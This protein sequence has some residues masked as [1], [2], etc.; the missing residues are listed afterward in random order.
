MLLGKV[1][2]ALKLANEQ[3]DIAG[4]H[5]LDDEPASEDAILP[6]EEQ[7]VE[8][9]TYEQ[10][11]AEAVERAARNM[12]GSGG[13]TQVDADIWKV[14]VCSKA[15]GNATLALRE[16]ITLL[17]RR[18]C[19]EEIPYENIALL[20]SNRLV[21]LRKRDD[22]VRPV[23][24]GETLRRI[25]GKTVAKAFKEDIQNSCGPL[26]TCTGIQSGIEAAIHAVKNI[27]LQDDCEAVLLVDADNAFNR[28][29]REV[30]LKNVG[31]ICPVI[32]QYIHNSYK[33]PAKLYLPDGSHILSK[34][35]TTQGD[36]I[37][38]GMYAIGTKPLIDK[39]H[40]ETAREQVMQV[41]F[42]DDSTAGGKIQGI[43]TWWNS[44]KENGPKYGYFPKPEKTYLIVKDPRK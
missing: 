37:A 41:W 40:E 19:S 35:G 6:Q 24:V 8:P 11:N 2:Q 38:M 10:I 14:M 29:N 22:G 27:F 42:A 30:A 1:K 4:V 9:V 36:N 18:L 34:E 20:F 39:L 43:N 7:H 12:S 44:L 28:L 31:Q 21:P 17:A 33:E 3:E 16:G 25:I 23:G 5:T 32:F 13:P 15:Y 26:Q